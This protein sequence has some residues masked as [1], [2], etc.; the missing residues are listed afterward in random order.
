MDDDELELCGNI[1]DLF[2]ADLISYEHNE[3]SEAKKSVA[4]VNEVEETSRIEQVGEIHLV[5]A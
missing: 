1:E 4:T 2:G 3:T 5:N